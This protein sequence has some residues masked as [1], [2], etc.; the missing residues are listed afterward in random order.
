MGKHSHNFVETFGGMGAYGLDRKS[1]EETVQL[2]LQKFSGDRLMEKVLKRMTDQDMDEL[3]DMVGR[4][5]KQYLNEEE[6]HE[7][8]L[9]D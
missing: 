5:L 2:Y 7:L 9:K 6:Y 4:L 3:F 1:N 8:F